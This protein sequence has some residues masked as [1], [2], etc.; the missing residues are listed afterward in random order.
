MPDLSEWSGTN[1]HLSLTFHENAKN[2]GE[3]GNV[4]EA[5]ARLVSNGCEWI[6]LMHQ[7]DLVNADWIRYCQHYIGEWR[8]G[9][10]QLIFPEHMA[11]LTREGPPEALHQNI[12]DRLMDLAFIDIPPLQAGLDHVSDQW[13]W[14]PSGTLFRARSYHDMGGFFQSLVYAGDNDFLVRWLLSGRSIRQVR[15]KFVYKRRHPA[16]QT[17]NCVTN[18]WDNEG[19][20]YLMHRYA[21][22]KTAKREVK[23]HY[24]WI[25]RN[26]RAVAAAL[27]QKNF[28]LLRS[29][30]SG[31][32][33]ALRNYLALHLPFGKCLLPAEV[34]RLLKEAPPICKPAET[35]P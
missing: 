2:V 18:G 13:A 12:G 16:S 1:S 30:L 21:P 24:D 33:I 27:R 31:I 25:Y 26:A 35:S 3:A 34:R 23:D 15:C 11:F 6:L 14:T 32:A 8:A 20:C 17:A 19:W 10:P 9:L 4:N 7:D 22:Y 28:R 5:V 29:R